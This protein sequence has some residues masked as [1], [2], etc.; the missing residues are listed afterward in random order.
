MRI[1]L[2]KTL[3]ILIASAVFL[4]GC[5]STSVSMREVVEREGCEGLEKKLPYFAEMEIRKQRFRDDMKLRMTLL[6]ISFGLGILANYLLGATYIIPAFA[7]EGFQLT[8]NEVGAVGL[9][10][11]LSATR[12]TGSKLDK[13]DDSTLARMCFQVGM[14]YYEEGNWAQAAAYF[15]SL[16]GGVYELYIGDHNLL[17]LLGKCYYMLDIYDQSLESYRLF[18]ETAPVDDERRGQV[19]RSIRIVETLKNKGLWQ[20]E[21]VE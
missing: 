7:P 3:R 19:K 2:S 5:A 10:R 20:L 21:S 8:G 18:L 15:E 4:S 11:A 16:R 14:C 6:P 12:L 13:I 9:D 1:N 17:F